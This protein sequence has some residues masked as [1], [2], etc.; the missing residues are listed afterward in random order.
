MCSTSRQPARRRRSAGSREEAIGRLSTMAEGDKGR[1]RLST[2][3]NISFFFCQGMQSYKRNQRGV[4]FPFLLPGYSMQIINVD[5][6]LSPLIVYSF[7]SKTNNCAHVFFLSI[8][9]PFF[10]W[11]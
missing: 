4:I 10:F 8:F 5:Y 9:F 11:P 7:L 6:T 1:A 3:G 2:W